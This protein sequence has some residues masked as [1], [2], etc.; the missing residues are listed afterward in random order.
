MIYARRERFGFPGR[1]AR[2]TGEFETRKLGAAGEG[3]YQL[4]LA[5]NAVIE[6]ITTGP[7]DPVTIVSSA[8]SE[9][10][11]RQTDTWNIHVVVTEFF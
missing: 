3:E 10:G 6:G 5:S 1:S 8:V 4:D 7:G 11:Q 2:V 9:V